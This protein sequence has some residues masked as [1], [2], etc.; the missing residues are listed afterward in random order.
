MTVSRRTLLKKYDIPGPRYTSYPTVPYWEGPPTESEWVECLDRALQAAERIGGGGA[1][2]VHIPFCEKKCFFCGCHSEVTHNPE[3]VSGYVDT[4]LRE[5]DTYRER[6]GRSHSIPLA[7]I[8]LGG[9]TPTFLSEQQ[10]ARLVTYLLET[11][12]TAE[13]RELSVEVDP[14]VTTEAQLAL[15]AAFGF[16]RVSLGI[17]DFDPEVQTLIG[18][19]QSFEKVERVT[20]C[21]RALGFESVNFDLLYGLPLQ[22]V[23]SIEATIAAVKRLRP[24]RIAFYAYAHIPWIRPLQKRFRNEDVPTGDKKRI[25][26]DHGRQLLLRMGYQEVGMD[27]FSLP[28]DTLWHAREKGTLHRNFMGYVSRQASPLIGLGVTAIG[29]SWTAFAQNEKDLAS[30]RQRVQDGHLPIQTGHVL[31]DEDRVLRR[32]ILNLMTRFETHWNDETQ[33]T[34]YLSTIPGRVSEMVVDELVCVGN[35]SL[36]I[37]DRG[38]PFVRNVAMLFDARLSRRTPE[39]ELFSRT[40]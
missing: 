22:S 32:H 33:W 15:L 21:A 8:H 3:V 1:V 19:V 12:Q 20:S 25:L 5:W 30:Y 28:S 4:V 37:T 23:T 29:D 36:T 18:R 11:S 16:K 2:Y 6:L 40:I 38:R 24:E 31:T 26:Y 14:R 13:S 39:T 34:P 17:Q 9:G 10:L 35:R 7:E 27:H